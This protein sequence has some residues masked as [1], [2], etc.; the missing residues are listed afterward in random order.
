M[1]QPTLS[2]VHWSGILFIFLATLAS[3]YP[4]M[5]KG[6]FIWDDGQY[7]TGNQTLKDPDGLSQIWL[8]PSSSPNYYPMVFTTFWV[9]YRLWR[10]D[11]RGYHLTNVLLHAV[12]AILVLIV[13][14]RLKVPGALVA[15]AVFA[16]HPVHVE[17]VAWIAERKNVLS[18]FFF[19]AGVLSWLRFLETR[20]WW[21]Y[22]CLVVCFLGAMLSKTVVCTMPVVLLLLAWYRDPTLW[23]REI[24][25][26]IPLFA[27]SL[28]FGVATIWWERERLG[29]Q[30]AAYGLSMMD[31]FLA[32]GRIPWFY[33]WKLIWPANLFAIY[34]RW[35]LDPTD[36]KQYLFP[37]ASAALPVVPWLFR[38]KWGRGVFTAVACFI[39]MLGPAMGFIDFSTM[40]LSLVADHY[41]YHASIGLIA[42][43]GALVALVRSRLNLSWEVKSTQVGATA[44]LA[45]LGLL[46]W[47]QTWV[48]QD[49][50][51]L[52]RHA[53]SGNPNCWAVHNNLGDAIE[54]KA[55]ER[56]EDALKMG[57]Q[58]AAK[59]A[60]AQFPEAIAHYEEAAR[61]NPGVDGPLV[62]IGNAQLNEGQSDEAVQSYHRALAAHPKSS[63][64]YYKLGRLYHSNGK[65]IEA[66]ENFKKAVDIR[67]RYVEALNSLGVL[68]A[69]RK[70]FEMAVG[71]FQ[72]VLEINPNH[73]NARENFFLAQIDWHNARV[74]VEHDGKAQATPPEAATHSH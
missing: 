37:L 4:V 6:D 15:A 8:E 32:A 70:N 39:V 27:I 36:W 42:L 58:E 11:P 56:L 61:L 5:W 74:T 68:E 16:V 23:K 55:H 60:R 43:A 64:A 62:N 71:Y 49:S 67:P 59:A 17:S 7:V 47:R 26:M 30:E 50:E 57:D 38:E 63:L 72:R 45:A 40:D 46:T 33:L 52:W 19:L 44:C 41:F 66:E 2:R 9:E 10:D 73:K 13:L 18:G 51:A 34:P 35:N 24:L 54:S 65:E 21:Q 53:L 3:Y 12:N 20:S 22:L 25:P 29:A 48:Y 31:R 14:V 1:S 28:V 69:Q